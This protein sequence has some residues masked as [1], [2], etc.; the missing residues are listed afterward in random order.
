MHRRLEWSVIVAYVLHEPFSATL[1]ETQST[2][3]K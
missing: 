1:R 2:T 3:V